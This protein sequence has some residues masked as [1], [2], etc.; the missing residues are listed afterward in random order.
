MFFNRNLN[1]APTPIEIMADYFAG[2]YLLNDWLN[3]D[4]PTF[5]IKFRYYISGHN[6]ETFPL[7]EKQIGKFHKLY[8]NI[9]LDIARKELGI[10]FDPRE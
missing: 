4:F 3:D 8:S 2:I 5:S 6:L 1:D 7:T 10:G 9:D